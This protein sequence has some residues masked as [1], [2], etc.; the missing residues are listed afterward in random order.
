MHRSRRN[1]FTLVEVLVSM[2]IMG[3][4]F[5]MLIPAVSAARESARVLSCRNNSRQIGLSLHSIAAHTGRMPANQP[6]PWTVEAVRL[7]DPAL[8]PPESATDREVAW[9]LIPVARANVSAFLCPSGTPVQDEPRG[10]S[11]YAFNHLLPGLRPAA[12]TDGLTRTL[13]TAEIPSSAATPWTWGPLA[14]DTNVGSG[15]YR[16]VNVSFA[17]GSARG[18]ALPIDNAVLRSILDPSDGR[19]ISTD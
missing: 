16:L 6:A 11:N 1:A 12:V 8:L 19:W 14:D 17:D 13:L 10:I 9:D 2:A 3:A 5:A 15:H 18:M 7:I 4:I